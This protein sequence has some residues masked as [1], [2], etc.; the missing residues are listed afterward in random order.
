MKIEKGYAV[1]VSISISMLLI[2]SVLMTPVIADTNGFDTVPI[3]PL[4]QGDR[5]TLVVYCDGSYDHCLR[6]DGTN[7]YTVHDASTADDMDIHGIYQMEFGQ[8]DLGYAGSP[9]WYIWRYYAYFDTSAIPN[10]ATI[11]DVTFTF[12]CSGHHNPP[13]PDP[14]LMAFYD[15]GGTY[16]HI[17]LQMGDFDI[18]HY[19]DT[20]AGYYTIDW[21]DWY[22]WTWNTAGYGAINK[23]GWTKLMF[24]TQ[25]DWQANQALDQAKAVMWS[26]DYTE[27]RP[28]L[29]I[30]YTSSPPGDPS[31]LNAYNPTQNSI[32]LSWTKGSGSDYTMI[33]R[34]TGGYPSSPSDGAQAYYGTGTSTVDAGLSPSTTYYYRAWA[35]DS[36]TGLY[37]TGYSQDYATTTSPAPPGDPSNLNAFNPSSSAID[38]SWIKGSG[39][40]KTMI[41]RGTGGYPSSPTSGTQVYF[42][43]GVATTDSGLSAGTR[44]YYRAWAYDSNTG[45]YSTGYSSDNDYTKPGDPS[46]LNAYNPTQNSISLSW[47]KG[48]GGDKTMIR[49][50][51]GGYPSSPT[52]GTQVYFSTGT[53]ITDAGLSPS[54]TYYYRAW[55]YDSDSTY[56]STGYSQDYETTTGASSP[57]DPSNLNAYN[58]TQNSISLSWTKGSG[59]DYT[60]IRRSIGS[61]P[62]SPSSGSQ[63]YYGTGT[64]TVDS[65]LNPGTTY[66]Y[67]AWAYDSGTGLYSTGYTQDYETTTGGGE[68]AEW[69]FMVYL[70]ADNNLHNYGLEDMNEMEV[71]GSTD[72]VQIIV[73]FDGWGNGDSVLYRITQDPNGYHPTIVSTILDDQGA[74]IPGSGEVNMGDPQTAINFGLWAMT[75]YPANRY[76]YVFWDHGNGWRENQVEQ[77]TKEV[78][79]D[80]TSGGDALT[81]AE[82]RTVLGAIS[83]NGNDPIDLVGFD[84]CLMQMIEVGYQIADFGEFMTGSEANEPG[85]GWNYDDTL[86]VLVGTPTMSPQNLGAQIVSDFIGEGG[87]TLS[88]INL[89]L[90][91]SLRSDVSDLGVIL[92]DETYR[93]EV[94]DALD[95]VEDYYYHRYGDL[96][97]FAQLIRDYI[98]D[99]GVDACAQA[100]MNEVNNVVTSENHNSGYTNSHGLSIYAPQSSYSQAYADLLFA[101]DSQ[102]DEFLS[103]FHR[104]D[105]NT[106][107]DK[108]TINGPHTIVLGK[109]YSYTFVCVDPEE[110]DVFYFID[111]GDGTTEEWVGPYAS[112][113]VIVISHI[114]EKTDEIHS[115]GTYTIRARAK[116]IHDDIGEWE[117]FE[118]TIPKTRL[119]HHPFF[120]RLFER[121]PNR[122]PLLRG[123]FGVL[124][125]VR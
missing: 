39:A 90:L 25:A 87:Y 124:W 76:A 113:E 94:Q 37:S 125:G 84:A 46:N 31:N 60:T 1:G 112:D 67:R 73:L 22:T 100:V 92:N 12:Y 93:N 29:T 45:M 122:F 120:Y 51:T 59:A 6:K 38:L 56:Y 105:N 104:S 54:T 21:L 32:S 2:V 65:G 63:A 61:Y 33:R 80:S 20:G 95:D 88:T 98:N 58:P 108:P 86:T 53:T 28:Y 85:C 13:A 26:G 15:T 35:Y 101:Q 107:P 43:T 62:S 97:H 121:F 42:G 91:D 111:W 119:Q 8:E 55:A 78:C 52:S 7:Y 82:L 16:P 47:A 19:S 17:P 77:I 64:S 99:A 68:I 10:D 9:H 110:E 81:M 72:D 36:G 30:E 3:A 83:N 24:T 70:D 69:T 89:N 115:R 50:G 34:K 116:D 114:W 23:N 66:Y 117:T 106:P 96:Y 18:D 11:T 79:G 118:I 14:K 102:W 109:E 4:S 44:Y 27:Y 49:R 123:L 103:W 75:Q 57:G 48:T 5:S 74:V 41:R 40:D 71:A